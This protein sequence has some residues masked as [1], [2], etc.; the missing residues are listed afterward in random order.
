[1]TEQE[2]KDL[3]LSAVSEEL[4][5]SPEELQRELDQDGDFVVGSQRAV[6]V[7]A[8]LEQKVKRKLAGAEELEPEEVTTFGALLKTLLKQLGGND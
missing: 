5:R 7:I 4:E 2:V 6:S 1:M 3:L 8:A